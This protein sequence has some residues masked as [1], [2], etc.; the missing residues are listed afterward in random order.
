[1]HVPSMWIFIKMHLGKWMTSGFTMFLNKCSCLVLNLAAVMAHSSGYRI[2]AQQYSSS[3]SACASEG[4][5]VMDLGVSVLLQSYFKQFA[6]SAWQP[7]HSSSP[8]AA[9]VLGFNFL[10]FYFMCTAFWPA[11]R[12]KWESPFKYF[13]KR[14]EILLLVA[15][16]KNFWNCNNSAVIKY[17]I[18]RLCW[19]RGKCSFFTLYS[20]AW[21]YGTDVKPSNTGMTKFN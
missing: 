11:Q 7:R 9:G 16:D 3:I 19:L 13:G 2:T 21:V 12:V 20:A 14:K 15:Q 10:Y 8:T 6:V 1:M 17:S 5:K 18:S 4:G